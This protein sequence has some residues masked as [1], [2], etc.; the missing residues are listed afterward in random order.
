MAKH[1]RVRR[2]WP[3]VVQ[4]HAA[5]GLSVT[6][7]CREQGIST[8]LLYRWRQRIP[9]EA[10]PPV[11]DGFVEVRPIDHQTAGSGV[12]VVVDG[13][14]RLELEPGFDA[15]TLDRVLACVTRRA[16]CSP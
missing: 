1:K 4:A 8:S 13:G 12:A 6:A 16:V 11:A 10:A 14:W 2:D 7:F 3:A 15:A 5:S 9:E